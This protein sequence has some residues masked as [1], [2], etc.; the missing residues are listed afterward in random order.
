MFWRAKSKRCCIH[1]QQALS[2][3]RSA[4]RKLFSFEHL[5]QR[6]LL[7]GVSI[8]AGVVT[9]DGT[10]DNDFIVVSPTS[11][12]ADLQVTL[13][14]QVISDSIPLSSVTEIDVNGLEGDDIISL[15]SIDKQA[16]VDGGTG[17]NQLSVVGH[18]LANSFVLSASSLS[19]NGLPY[20]F[21]NI[22]QLSVSGQNANDTFT[23]SDL[24]TIPVIFD[25]SSG[26]DTLQGPDAANDWAINVVNGGVL[27]TTLRFGGMENLTG[28]TDVDT[29]T[30]NPGAS[31]SSKV[32]GG[33][34]GTDTISYATRGT[35]VTVD[36]Q[37]TGATNIGRFAN[38]DNFV[39][40]TA[41]NTVIGSNQANTWNISAGN[42]TSIAGVT[43]SSFENLTGNIQADVFN[44]LPGGYVTGKVD[45]RAGYD[46]LT[47]NSYT[48]AVSL[49]V[50]Q[51]TFSGAGSGFFA[52]VES[53][54]GSATADTTLVGPNI[55]TTWTI[56][57]TNSGKVGAIAFT[58]VRNLTGGF[59]NDTFL[60]GN[61]TGVTGVI[62]GGGGTDI[63]KYSQYT[64]PITVNLTQPAL[65]TGAGSGIINVEGV[66]GGSAGDTLVGPNQVNT[67]GIT[68]NNIGNLNGFTFSS[69]ENLT[70]GAMDDTFSF[71]KAGRISGSINGGTGAGTFNELD[72]SVF[73]KAVSV[74]LTA[75]TATNIAGGVSN[76]T[77]V[78]G[79]SAGDVLIG[80]TQDNFLSGNGGSDYIAGISGNNIL[81]GGAGNDTLIGAD[82][83]DLLFGGLGADALTGGAGEDILFNG[84]TS[85]DGD[86][87]TIN[88]IAIVWNG[89]DDFAT[90]VA[91]LRA[92]MTTPA[93]DSTNVFN[94]TVTDKL[95]GGDDLDWYFAKLSALGKTSFS[96]LP[97]AKNAIKPHHARKV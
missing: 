29:F 22:Q 38:I 31:I 45:G 41:S 10:T 96:T 84:T 16:I 77:D 43:L 40:S 70:G 59:K 32:D 74:N 20:A 12:G 34:G 18:A 67:W 62:D 14:G 52:S 28:G 81:I 58:Q 33:T 83:R 56:N 86:G 39:G 15:R 37:F 95:T 92:G 91:Q 69:I 82:G 66:I 87:A 44:F 3:C 8:A 49:N 71:S 7:S 64:T 24:P 2:V 36:L 21:P 50:A 53:L 79:G 78:L 19:V 63:L 11:S 60:F 57:N 30:M 13:N 88:S 23:V 6:K 27:N 47:F 26:S 93:L 25:G 54:V 1:R 73:S 75:H 85:F 76:I 42:V 72:Y 90:R 48:T 17:T 94:D 4:N 68:S 35:P 46:S 5:E 51:A 61:G 55:N 97:P 80:D 89:A 65:T 9:V